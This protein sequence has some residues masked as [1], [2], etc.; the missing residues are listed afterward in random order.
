[1]AHFF[2]YVLVSGSTKDVRQRVFHLMAPYNNEFEVEEYEADCDCNWPRKAPDPDCEVCGGTGR[3]FTTWNPMSK[4]DFYAI[5]DSAHVLRNASKD[6]SDWEEEVVYDDDIPDDE[7]LAI[8]PLGNLDLDR[9][10]LPFAIV[11]PPGEWH[12]MPGDWWSENQ[13]FAA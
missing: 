3:H 6:P 13:D 5:W 8:A 12:E 1:M 10:K 9:L 4:F 7:R 2:V 11:T